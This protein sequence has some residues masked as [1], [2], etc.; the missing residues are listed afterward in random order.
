MRRVGDDLILGFEMSHWV[1]TVGLKVT[2]NYIGFTLRKLDYVKGFGDNT[3]HP[4]DEFTILQLPVRNRKYF[5]DWL[6]VMWD[7]AVAVNVLA[8]D[9]F[10]RLMRS[11][12]VIT[13]FFKPRP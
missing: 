5:G 9:P 2:D 7:D 11:S 3:Q 13:L 12:I 8:T 4:I 6:N 10:P 1:A